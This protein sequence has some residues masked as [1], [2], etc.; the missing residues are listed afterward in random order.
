M[1]LPDLYRELSYGE[2][3]NLALG[4]EGTGAISE[5]HQPRIVQFAN[6]ALLKLY[7]RFILKESTVII[8]AYEHITHYHLL[9]RFTASRVAETGEQYPYIQDIYNERFHED[10]I[11]I[12]AVYND[13]G[14]DYPLNDLEDRRSLFTPT[15][16][17]LQI[18]Q[19]KTGVFY[20]VI[21]QAKHSP[22]EFNDEEEEI[23][24]PDVLIP[25]LR[26]YIAYLVLSPMNTQDS[27][28]KAQ[29][30][31]NNYMMICEEAIQQ[32]LVNTSISQTNTRFAKRGW[33]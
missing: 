25:A 7:S 32:D 33:I 3:S 6:E 31:L 11:K 27:T 18:P 29:E 24:L 14:I 22:L 17:S 21:Y 10:V 28:T 2:L 9:K 30:H 13:Q 8:S 15:S 1:K 12:L 26:A 4:V 20:N 5:E 19:A 23:I 16:N